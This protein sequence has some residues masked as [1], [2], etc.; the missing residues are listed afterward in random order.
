MNP[1]SGRELTTEDL[2]RMAQIT[3]LPNPEAVDVALQRLINNKMAD[4]ALSIWF[5][6]ARH[7]LAQTWVDGQIALAKLDVSP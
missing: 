1:W 5:E 4:I 6:R 7:D 2:D 3:R